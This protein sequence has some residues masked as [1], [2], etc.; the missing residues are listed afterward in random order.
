MKK[1]LFSLILLF[2]I[3]ITFNTVIGATI[4]GAEIL[5]L[6]VPEITSETIDPNNISYYN[7]LMSDSENYKPIFVYH[8]VI[9]NGSILCWTGKAPISQDVYSYTP[10]STDIVTNFSFPN[11]KVGWKWS[12]TS[13]HWDTYS[14][15]SGTISFFL[16]NTRI[17]YNSTNIS[18]YNNVG[19]TTLLYEPTPPTN[20]INNIT[21]N[22]NGT[23]SIYFEE[24]E[25]TDNK[26]TYSLSKDFTGNL[27]YPQNYTFGSVLYSVNVSPP[28]VLY[29]E[30]RTIGG[31]LLESGSVSVPVEQLE[32][33]RRKST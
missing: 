19:K 7:S 10:T 11:D 23:A 31:E 29:W 32:P 1:I 9:S 20:L 14:F 15:G 12:T 22:N 33:R 17:L 3:F 24:I 18:V 13:Q 16:D 5:E 30:Y 6:P 27:L 8:G 28:T 25:S 2:L 21:Y 26:L 4:N